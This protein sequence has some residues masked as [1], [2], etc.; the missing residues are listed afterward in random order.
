[1]EWSFRP[2]RIFP[3]DFEEL[4]AEDYDTVDDKHNEED[5]GFASFW[6]YK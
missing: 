2:D 5:C 3:V 4:T 6:H 1:M